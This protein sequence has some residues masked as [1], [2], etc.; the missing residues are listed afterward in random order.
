MLVEF[1]KSFDSINRNRLGQNEDTV[2]N[3][4][5]QYSGKQLSQGRTST[6]RVEGTRQLSPAW[7][8]VFPRDLY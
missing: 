8:V 7:H 4:E 3:M 1:S 6:A 2:N 5:G